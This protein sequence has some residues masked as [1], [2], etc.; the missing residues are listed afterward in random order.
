MKKTIFFSVA[1][2]LAG[3]FVSSCSDDV[4]NVIDNNMVYNAS[5]DA[6]TTTLLNG[7]TDACTAS[8]VAK[9]AQP[10]SSDVT[11]NYGVDES[12]VAAYNAI[13]SEN[14]IILP[15]ANYSLPTAQTSI[16]KGA[17]QSS[18]LE[19]AFKDLNSL[20]DEQVYVLPVSIVNA[21]IPVLQ[22]NKTTYY[23]FRGA[24]LI[25]VV[26]NMEN[27]CLRLKNPGEATA[28][29]S[30]DKL[31]V[32]VLLYPQA[33]DNMLSTV[34]GIEGTF[35]FR[36]GDSGVPSNQIQLATA[37]GNCTDSAWQLDLNTWTHVALTYDA[38]T[39]A[40]DVYFN[41]I[42]K[43]STQTVG[44]RNAVNW[45][46]VSDDRECYIGYA[47][48]PNRDFVG[49]M[50]ELRVW[51]KIL[52]ADDLAQRNHFYSVEADSEGLCAYWKFDE[53]AGQTVHDYAN[54]YDMYV[55]S[56]YPGQSSSPDAM[57]WI[58]VALPK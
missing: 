36:I 37:S 48:D 56:T 2:M 13:Y 8:L 5:S 51:N 27:T 22:N 26:G 20:N 1:M 9:I 21:S 25:N 6:V 54:G 49:Y 45:N 39:G 28:L 32:E 50:S 23:V 46:V 47:Y 7:K 19:I 15:S 33:F 44:Y 55:P 42:K 12:A 3:A 11:I 24:S 35:L 16:I 34:I 30:L 17:V 41:G 38:S 58:S 14:A 57:Q 18:A 31:T 53:G 43:G 52:T 10:E 4:E 29:G 40:V